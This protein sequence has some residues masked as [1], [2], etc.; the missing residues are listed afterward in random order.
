MISYFFAVNDRVDL[1]IYRVI[2]SLI[3]K[4]FIA[5]CFGG[6]YSYTTELFPTGA[7]SAAIG[8][9][10]TSGRIGGVMAPIIAD[11]VGTL[12]IVFVCFD[13]L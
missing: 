3:G 1:G 10:S 6:I 9:C 12:V 13:F 4:L 5:C 7:R 8:L 2:L 11:L